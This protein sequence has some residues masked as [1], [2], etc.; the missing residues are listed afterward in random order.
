[1]TYRIVTDTSCNLPEDLIDKFE[2]EILPLTFMIDGKQYHSYTKEKTTDLK[3]F[4]DMMRDGKVITT[5]LPNLVNS[6]ATF[7]KILSEGE[8]ILYL[9]FSSGLSGTYEAM[10][11]LATDLRTRYPERTFVCIDTLAAS[12]GQG[13][14]IYYAALMKEKGASLEEVATWV[15]DN[16]LNLCH[17][18]TV[19]DLM[20]LYRGGRV[21]R[22]SAFAANLLSIKPVL[23]VDNEGHLIPMEKARGRKKSIQ[24]MVE[25]MAQTANQPVD[26][27][28][29]AISHGD[30]FA[31]V[32]Y[33]QKLLTERFGIQ[34]YIVNY[35]DPVIGAHS[36]PGT[37][38][39]FFLGSQR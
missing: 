19:D 12:L 39:L 17:W 33:L 23:H 11:T 29:I 6:E 5:S 21:S 2:L 22:T 34:D 4:Y 24:A 37:L 16:R 36:G 32:E 14:L 3:M 15:N 10:E 27:Q 20:Y 18:F 26:S 31:D 9:G 35:V 7:E 30:C 13:L 1:M 28:V 25:H 38:A 8:D